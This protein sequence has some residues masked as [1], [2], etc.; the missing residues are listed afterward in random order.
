MANFD[1]FKPPN[2]QGQ[3]TARTPQ[4]TKTEQA[5][6]PPNSLNFFDVNR[7]DAQAWSNVGKAIQNAG[8]VV[9]DVLVKLKESEHQNNA[10][11]F[12]LK[13]TEKVNSLRNELNSGQTTSDVYDLTDLEG[14]TNYFKMEEEK[15]YSSLSQE[16]NREGYKRRDSLMRDR[17]STPYLNSMSSVRTNL[18]QK[19][20]E[21]NKTAWIAYQDAKSKEGMDLYLNHFNALEDKNELL[22]KKTRGYLD[23]FFTSIDQE[24]NKRRA[25]GQLTQDQYENSKYSIRRRIQKNV[26]SRMSYESPIK[27][28]NLLIKKDNDF[29][30][31]LNPEDYTTNIVRA[32]KNKLVFDNREKAKL[33]NEE[34]SN[35]NFKV[36]DLM[37]EDNYK[38]LDLLAIQIKNG[39]ILKNVEEHAR[40]V[41]YRQLTKSIKLHKES[42]IPSTRDNMQ[43]IGNR[44]ESGLAN[45]LDFV[46]RISN[47]DSVPASAEKTLAIQLERYGNKLINAKKTMILDNSGSRVIDDKLKELN[48]NNYMKEN[49]IPKE[50]FILFRNSHTKWVRS[51]TE[52]RDKK[53]SD[54]IGTLIKDNDGD[55]S[56]QKEDYE[57]IQN[58]VQA[59]NTKVGP[60]EYKLLKRDSLNYSYGNT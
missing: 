47:L 16:F 4:S 26:A 51:V 6:P 25:S 17:K 12:Y 34:L 50:N 14:R 39:G 11:E 38:G 60:E 59:F 20:S 49:N 44:F 54:P 23:A 2:Y 9:S 55:P 3:Q 10:D 8:S 43:D 21:K 53:N 56:Y 31:H 15:I 37:S 27:L 57:N 7:Y 1:Y 41:I 29:F 40:S 5:T 42:K 22:T 52:Y 13:Y 58:S 28:L 18:I 35:L 46:P 36:A 32:L 19:I 48:V 45:T 33:Q 24:A 30:G